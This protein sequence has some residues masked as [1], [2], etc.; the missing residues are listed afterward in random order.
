MPEDP[1]LN[2]D[3]W[4]SLPLD[5]SADDWDAPPAVPSA[6]APP[7]PEEALAEA[8]PE[9]E[10][11]PDPVESIGAAFPETADPAVEPDFEADLAAALPAGLEPDLS[12]FDAP[13]VLAEAAPGDT[14]EPPVASDEAD[15]PW[16]ADV[17]ADETFGPPPNLEP[18]PAATPEPATEPEPD[19]EIEVAPEEPAPVI[20][21]DSDPDEGDEDEAP[22]LQAKDGGETQAAAAPEPPPQMPEVELNIEDL[23]TKKVELDI[24]G[25]FLE[26]AEAGA[27]AADEPQPE[28]EPTAQA[29]EKPAEAAPP[30]EPVKRKIPKAK[31]LLIAVPALLLLL[32]L[33]FGAYTLFFA[34]EEKPVVRETIISPEAPPRDPEPGDMPVETLYVGF[35]GPQGDTLVEILVVLHYN[36]L[37]DR[38]LITDRLPTLRDIIYRAVQGKGAAMVSDGEIQRVLREELA[39]SLNQALGRE[40]VNYV[41]ITQIRI[42]H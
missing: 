21:P 20:G 23:S 29:T 7:P 28:P 13:E 17:P 5:E 6:P 38:A 3:D 42:L 33:L 41:Q 4:D 36:D 2:L 39:V 24:D 22:F 32:G 10:I 30:P 40:A 11:S 18:E 12:D 37:P 27:P 34:E 9:P 35:P 15:E 14:P 31:L 26:S 25:I 8:A 19:F 16:E 1:K